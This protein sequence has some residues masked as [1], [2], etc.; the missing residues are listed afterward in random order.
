M[1]SSTQGCTYILFDVPSMSSKIS[2]FGRFVRKRAVHTR[3]L[4]VDLRTA[5]WSVNLD[6]APSLNAMHRV[7]LRTSCSLHVHL[8]A[9]ED[10]KARRRMLGNIQF[11]GE[12]FK[13]KMLTEKI[14]HECIVKLLGN[15]RTPASCG[16]VNLSVSVGGSTSAV[17]VGPKL[18][19]ARDNRGHVPP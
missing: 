4:H 11:I 16:S 15:V 13:E 5:F 7:S 19:S 9:Q 1:W 2:Q 3:D 14:M 12:L 17:A 6:G 10:L 8:A 18:A